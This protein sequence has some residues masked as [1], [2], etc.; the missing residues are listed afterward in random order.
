MFRLKM[1]LATLVLATVVAAVYFGAAGRWDLPL[2][3]GVLGAMLTFHL[4]L[5]AFADLGMV[6]ERIAP[7]P[8]SRDRVTRPVGSVLLLGHWALAGLDVGRFQWSVIPWE[9]QAIGLVG[10][11]VAM[12]FLFWVIR[13]NRFY[14]S[15]VRVQSD[16]G[17]HAVT[18][19]PYRFVRHPGYAATIL[20]GLTGGL[21]LGSWLGLLPVMGF[22]ALFLRR[23][24]LEERLLHTELTGYAE[25]AGRVR[26]RLVPGVF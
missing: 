24:L 23:T 10:Y 3:W 9:V 21:A 13:V 14:S 5:A 6:R 12:G 25:Y 17:H 2:A 15:V 20:A 18:D 1:T 22:I 4:S 11:V 7:G 16:R 8:G 19:G 26:Y